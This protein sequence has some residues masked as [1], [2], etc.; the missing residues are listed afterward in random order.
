[1]EVIMEKFVFMCLGAWICKIIMKLIGEIN[2]YHIFDK[3]LVS[4]Q[5]WKI[6]L[7]E[8]LTL[9]E[10]RH[11]QN[12]RYLCALNSWQNILMTNNMNEILLSW[13]NVRGGSYYR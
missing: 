10:N 12:I 2:A 8:F 3:M 6:K 1:M 4:D 11:R 7:V 9:M 13:E 5:W